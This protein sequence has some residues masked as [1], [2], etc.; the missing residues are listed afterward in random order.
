MAANNET[1]VI[2]DVQSIA[3]EVRRLSPK[4][5]IHTDAAQLLGK[6]PLS[7]HELGV[8]C[9]TVSGHKVGAL[10]GVGALVI[11]KGVE[12]APL[13]LG[14]AQEQKLR[15]G[16]ENVPGIVSFGWVAK[17]VG[18]AIEA[19]ATAMSSARDLLEKILLESISD[20]VINGATAERLPNTSSIWIPGIRA[21]DL[22]V[23]LDNEGIFVSSGA[24]CS[25]GKPEPSHVLLAMGQG[26]DRARETIRVSFHA[27]QTASDASF[28][29]QKIVKIVRRI[30]NQRASA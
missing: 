24:A 28:A 21:E 5:L 7:F 17:E 1:G 3:S 11:R 16:T 20:L 8:D 6:V 2:N 14:G 12:L 22:L 4:A 18:S 9:M 25:S 27:E 15:G 23:A 19:R 29:A 10:T 26:R 13:I 30:R